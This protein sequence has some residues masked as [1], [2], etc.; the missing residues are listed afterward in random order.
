MCAPPVLGSI[1]MGLA[2]VL[3]LLDGLGEVVE[4]EVEAHR[5]AASTGPERLLAEDRADRLP[6]G[7]RRSRAQTPCPARRGGLSNL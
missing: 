1:W 3:L 6:R 5:S 7:R 4:V 2:L